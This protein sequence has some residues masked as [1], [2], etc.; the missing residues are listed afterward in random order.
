MTPQNGPIGNH[1]ACHNMCINR[2]VGQ[3]Y[4]F[5]ERRRSNVKAA[6]IGIGGV[7]FAAVQ[8]S[9]VVIATEL[10]GV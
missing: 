4:G 9:S 10:V 6:V 5:K 7:F 1:F 2:P 8:L 3:K